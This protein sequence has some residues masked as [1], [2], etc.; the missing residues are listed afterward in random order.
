MATLR[1]FFSKLTGLTRRS[2]L[3]ERLDEELQFHIDMQTEENLSRGMNP[4]EARRQARIH[5]GGVEQIKELHRDVLRLGIL[6]ACLQ[7]LRFAWRSLRK[8]PGVTIA[9]LSIIALGIG[10]GTAVFSVV[11]AVLLHPMPYQD[12]D[13]LV[14]LWKVSE[15]Q[16][17]TLD[18]VTSGGFAD[19]FFS[20]LEYDLWTQR[21]DIF[22]SIGIYREQTTPVITSLHPPEQVRIQGCTPGFFSVLGVQPFLGTDLPEDDDWGP[23]VPAILQYEFWIRRFGGDPEVIGTTIQLEGGPAGPYIIV[24]VM[25][26]GFVFF[27]REIDMFHLMPW[28]EGPNTADVRNL[29]FTARLK[30]GITLEQAQLRAD[31]FSRILEREYPEIGQGWEVR[32]LPISEDGS[33]P[34][35]PT[36]AALAAAVFGVILVMC[37]N[38]AGL[39]LAKAGGRARE[40]AVRSAMGASR[41][42]LARLL[43]TE[44]LLLSILGGALGIGLSVQLISLLRTML[45]DR[46]VSGQF[47]L[48]FDWIGMDGTVLLFAVGATL[49][50][51]LLF[52]LAPSLRYSRRDVSEALKDAGH[53]ATGDRGMLRLRRFLIVSE[54]AISLVLVVGAMLL[55]RS[56]VNLYERGPGFQPEGL[57]SV[58]VVI[59]QWDM[60]LPDFGDPSRRKVIAQK[61][62]AF[63]DE[64]IAKVRALPGVS[65][66]ATGTN[67]MTDGDDLNVEVSLEAPPNGAPRGRA[68]GQTVTFNFFE[69]LGIPLLAGRPFT[70]EGPASSIIL[71]EQA[72]SLY[73]P[74]EDAIGQQL[75]FNGFP[76]QVLGVVGNLADNGLDQPP[77]PSLY[78]L[79]FGSKPRQQFDLFL[80]TTGEPGALV[81]ALRSAIHAVHPQA[82]LKNIRPLQDYIDNLSWKRRLAMNL[83]AGLAALAL[84]LATVGVY[85]VLSYVVSE[86]T[87]EI[88]I[89]MAL[90][91]NRQAV[92]RRIMGEGLKIAALGLGVGLIVAVILTRFLENLLYGVEPLDPVILA[93]SAATLGTAAL[94]ASYIPAR[95]AAKVDPMDALRFE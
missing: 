81:P 63:Y 10:V 39:L 72:A 71:N 53:R 3:D 22:E 16:G 87:R 74:G 73:F 20:P 30:D 37:A 59:P 52:G 32:L 19:V 25:P 56:V 9:A 49:F 28:G 65:S 31:D 13:R 12:P 8:T 85:G 18:D 90:G 46:D 83:L 50:A 80:R 61:S 58:R 79:Q 75:F 47:L 24:G 55:V 11:N 45:P 78:F 93:I 7:D 82:I 14:M 77:S 21:A 64:V 35:R 88:G 4:R 42:R 33:A 5:S 17:I 66:I 51:G 60:D 1:S 40:L 54:V 34:F 26:P 29:K 44:S 6:E 57:L 68:N 92:L 67:P 91:A 95:R 36:I 94:L 76:A 38:L 69:T 27:N 41:Q 70:E 89:R 48:R 2:E 84:L 62:G 43:L 23:G 86:R 15:Q